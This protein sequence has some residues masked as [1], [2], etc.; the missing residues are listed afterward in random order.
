MTNTGPIGDI[1]KAYKTEGT[2]SWGSLKKKYGI[3]QGTWRKILFNS[4]DSMNST[5]N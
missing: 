5:N 4:M 1:G 2:D 3:I